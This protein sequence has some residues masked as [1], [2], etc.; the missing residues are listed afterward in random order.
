MPQLFRPEA[1]TRFRL[2]LL[3]AGLALASVAGMAYVYARSGGAW[4]VGVKVEQPIPFRHD[5]HAGRLEIDCRY[6]HSTVERAWSAGMPSAQTCMTCHSQVWTGA[7]VLEPVR[8]SL[9]LEQP[10]AW[11]AVHDLPDFAHFHHGI[12]VSK[13]VACERCHGDVSSMAETKKTE[14]MS[15]GW[16]LECHTDPAPY[17]TVPE[18]LL[19]AT[20]DTPADAVKLL[21][22]YAISTERLTN[23]TACHY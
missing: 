11:N 18:A 7:S 23:C 9:A 22:H 6:C 19:P 3:L 8:S 5:V 15:M 2:G 17:L 20:P 1:N 4:N 13:G 12:H 14:T 21:A 16:C 10:I